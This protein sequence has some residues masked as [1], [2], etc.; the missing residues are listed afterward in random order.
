MQGMPIRLSESPGS[1]RH[2][3]PTLGQHSREVLREWLGK[4]DGQIQAMENAAVI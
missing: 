4:S 3:A 1:I 2:A